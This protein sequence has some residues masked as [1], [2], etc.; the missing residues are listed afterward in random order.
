MRRY[1][2]LFLL[3]LPVLAL[4]LGCGGEPPPVATVEV[5][6]ARLDLPHRGFI[7]LELTWRLERPLPDRV[8]RLRV[9]VHLLDE[10]GGVVRTC[11]LP[12]P[13]SGRPRDRGAY[14]TRLP[15]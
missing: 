1:R 4:A 11:D 9:F 7:P 5:K 15:P 8:G 13:G 6:S 2:S 10:P 12:C 14:R 3:S